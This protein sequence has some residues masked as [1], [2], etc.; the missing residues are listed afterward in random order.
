[1]TDSEL[2]RLLRSIDN[3][4]LKVAAIIDRIEQSGHQNAGSIADSLRAECV[5]IACATAIAMKHLGPGPAAR[6]RGSGAARCT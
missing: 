4:N 5:S 1:M 6:R 3:H 2:I